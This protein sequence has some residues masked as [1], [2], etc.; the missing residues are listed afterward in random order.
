MRDWTGEVAWVCPPTNLM[1]PAIKKIH[2]TVMT[3]IVVAPAWRTAQFWPFLFPDGE[4]AK[5]ECTQLRVV[6]PHIVKGTFCYNPLMQ[7]RTSFPFVVLY[8]ESR[9]K[10]YSGRTGVINMRW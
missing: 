10:R 8:V 4:N 3:A 7:G 6:Q 1:V 9:G 5:E 2:Y